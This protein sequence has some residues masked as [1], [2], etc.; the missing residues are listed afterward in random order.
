MHPSECWYPANQNNRLCIFFFIPQNT[1][2]KWGDI[3]YE[4]TYIAI[5][6]MVVPSIST[7]SLALEEYISFTSQ[8][9]LVL[10]EYSLHWN[11]ILLMKWIYGVQFYFVVKFIFLLAAKGDYSYWLMQLTDDWGILHILDSGLAHKI[12]S[13]LFSLAIT[14]L[15]VIVWSLCLSKTLVSLKFLFLIWNFVL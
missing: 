1:Y 12:W 11:K 8:R 3:S 5:P 6:L 4:L 10:E 13:L 14:E 7:R 15:K 9:L 2:F